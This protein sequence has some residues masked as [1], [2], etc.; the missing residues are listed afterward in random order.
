MG[1]RQHQKDKMYLTYTEWSQFYGGKKTESSENEH[2]KFKR[3]PFFHCTITMAPFENPYCDTEGN[4]FE[5]EAILAFHKK[6]KIN[7]I[8]GKPL[9]VKDLIKLTFY[10]NSDDA[11]HCPSLFKPFTKNSHIVAIATTGNVFS[12]EAVDQLNIKT[13]NWKDLVNDEAFTRKDII[14]IQDPSALEKFNISTFHHIKRKL[15]VETEEEKLEK[16]DPQGRLKT[17]SAE[18]KDIL[19]QL[20]KDYK[21]AVEEATTSRAVADKFNAAHYS[22]GAVAASF[23]STAMVPVFNHEAAILAD[24]EVRYE[25]VKKKGY[26][27]LV[28]SHG[29]L[30]IELYCNLVP[31]TCE[32]FMRH[33][34]DGYYNGTLF[35]RSV[36]NFM[37]QGGDP[38]GTGKGGQ[39]IWGKGFE[40]EIKPQLSHT[41]RGVVS[42]ANSG[43]NTNGSQFF[44]TYRSCKNLDGHHTI[45]GKLVGGMDSLNEMEKIEVD[46]NDRPIENIYILKVHVF[47]DPF[48]EADEQLAK[49]REDEIEKQRKAIEEEA[50][51]KQQ[52]NQP[53]KVY[54]DGIGKYLNI[55]GSG[56][57][58]TTVDNDD[59]VTVAKKQKRKDASYKFQNFSSW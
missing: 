38:K 23:T 6:Y 55:G 2:I 33:C 20:E 13:K 36:K 57:N 48:V 37:I 4:I 30:N 46:K 44:I 3:L 47:V 39:S 40:D 50:K 1:K 29:P 11:Y 14:T 9:A 54:R 59:D 12:F 22:T 43:P 25:R 27:Q 17:V 53:L 31:K 5:L 42:M 24:H 49:E 28:T 41:G 35:H 34:Q 15:R 51:R 8:T 26:V 21:P 56:S 45:F 7:P 52:K 19:Q 18:T 16:K 10:K 32:N 58:K